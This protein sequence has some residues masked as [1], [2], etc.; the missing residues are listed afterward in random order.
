[1]RPMT[2]VVV[3][4]EPGGRLGRGR[5]GL[6]GCGGWRWS[7]ERRTPSRRR[8]GV[9][10]RRR[11]S[12]RRRR[13]SEAGA[14]GLAVVWA[15]PAEAA[16]RSTARTAESAERRHDRENY[17]SRLGASSGAA[18]RMN[19]ARDLLRL[20]AAVFLSGAALMGA[21]D[22]GQPRPGARLRD[23]ALRVGRSH[24]D[25]PRGSRGGLRARRPPRG[26]EARPRAPLGHPPR[27]GRARD[28][29]SSRRPDAV[30]A[31]ASGAPV[32]D[33]FRAL[34][35]ALVLFAPPSVLMGAVTPFAVRLAAKELAPRRVG[36]RAAL[37]RLD[38]RLDPGRVRHGVLPDPDV[39]DPAD[40]LRHRRRAP[41]VRPSRPGGAAGAAASSRRSSS[42]RPARSSSSSDRASRSRLSRSGRW[43]SRRRRHITASASWTRGC[44]APSTS[45]T[46]LQGY[47]PVRPGIA[48]AINYT[49]GLALSIA[50]APAGPPRRLHRPRS[51]HAPVASRLARPGDRDD[52]HRDRPRGRRRGAEVLRVRARTRTTA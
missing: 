7:R 28:R 48:I 8:R 24:H 52:V 43:S 31:L 15:K 40:P 35:A 45:T 2:I 20:D 39:S 17:R 21:R 46:A 47:A 6:R 4:E 34:L 10:G 44:A 18:A 33:R 38:G 22:R 25:V 19:R 23:V 13:W 3:R 36:R 49:D 41:R 51:G 11:R 14:P 50:F 27:G 9:S 32:P 42:A 37:G 29:R 12:W 26:Q 30:L 5:L 16:R 1:M